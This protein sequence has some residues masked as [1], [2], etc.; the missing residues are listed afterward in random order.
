MKPSLRGKVSSAAEAVAQFVPDG[1]R[2]R[3][4]GIAMRKP[5]ALV[6]E[7]VRQGKKDLTLLL[8]G[9]TEDGDLLVGAGCV[10]KLEV[11]Y[12]G[13][14]ALGLAYN[15]RRAC[16]Q[17]IPNWIATEEY[18]NFGMTLRF[19]AGA[20]GLPF[21]P[22]KSHLGSDLP[23]YGSFLGKKSHEMDCPFSG[24]RVVLLPACQPDVAF[25]HA[26][27]CDQEGNVQIWGQIGDDNWGTLAAKRIV[28]SVEEV[29][30][31]EIVR[32][33]P[34]R[35]VVP[36][37]RVDAIVPLP[38]GAHPSQCQ[39]YYDLDLE[40]KTVYAERSRTR[41]GFL[42]YLDE[43]VYGVRN[44]AEYLA[45]LGAER[46]AKLKAHPCCCEPVNYGY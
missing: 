39:G 35:T 46:L 1:T 28:V 5:M 15:Y 20:M 34:N 22:C 40:F 26:Q 17:G 12:F 6:N 43:W 32:R 29:V 18:S 38:Y 25:L 8:A 27:R 21:M 33:D 13:L 2:L 37:F 3:T 36:G 10:S 19:M 4:G 14:E 41:E 31:S 11:A 16:E 45:K 44:H 42:S 30:D 9:L 7:V 24:E 23:R